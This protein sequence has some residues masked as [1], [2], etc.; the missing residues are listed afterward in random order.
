MNKLERRKERKEAFLKRK[1]EKK[2]KRKMHKQEYSSSSSECDSE[3]IE[4]VD[5][6]ISEAMRF[7]ALPMF[8]KPGKHQYLI[9]YKDST[10][11]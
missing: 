3:E 2:R 7:Y 10:E 11:V 8:I 9:K 1:L 5:A 6:T 4:K